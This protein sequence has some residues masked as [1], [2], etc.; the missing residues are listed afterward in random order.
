MSS[1][2]PAAA[3][4]LRPGVEWQHVDDEVV[5]LDLN[6]S[7]YMALN[8]TGS[9]LWPLVAAGTTEAELVDALSSRFT[10]EPG[11]ARAD[12]GAFLERLWSLSLVEN[13]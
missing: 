13:A 7:T 4:R 12:I 2:N 1:D 5:V 9:V 8:D 10:I 6:S 11:R 3:I